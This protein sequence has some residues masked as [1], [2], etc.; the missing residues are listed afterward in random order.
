MDYCEWMK[1]IAVFPALEKNV[2]DSNE[3]LSRDHMV[4]DRVKDV[5]SGVVVR[6][7]SMM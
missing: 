1:D 6:E 7:R 4:G 2:S 3:R 5:S